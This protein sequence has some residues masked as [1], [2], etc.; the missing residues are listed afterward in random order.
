MEDLGFNMA[1]S[2]LGAGFQ[3]CFIR[4]QDLWLRVQLQTLVLSGNP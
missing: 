2:H 4:V 3:C 1:S